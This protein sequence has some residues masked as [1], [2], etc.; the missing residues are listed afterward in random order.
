M[1]GR[2]AIVGAGMAGLA[3]AGRL[4]SAGIVATVFDKG[5]R[6]SGR[7]AARVVE[8]GG[9]RFDFDY[10]AQYMTARDCGFIA[11]IDQWAAQG[12]V[13]RWPVAGD[14]AWVGV[15]SMDAPLAAMERAHPVEWSS[16]VKAVQRR[17]DRW[18]LDIDG[19]D[20]GAFDELIL[21]LPAEQ[22]GT[23]ASAAAPELAVLAS[24]YPSA[25]CWT[26]MLGFDRPIDAPPLIEGDGIIDRACRM[27]AKPG[28]G[29]GEGWIVHA[30]ADWSAAHLEFERA[31]V[32]RLLTAALVDRI[33]GL[34]TPI[35]AAAHRWRFARS[36]PAGIGCYRD[37][38]IGIAACGDW[39][40]APRVESAWLSGVAA[41]EALLADVGR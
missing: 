33:E 9:H 13:A 21:A 34:P 18:H 6:P 8:A 20:R 29:P 38:A 36:S 37:A 26:L 24:K 32:S 40:T 3:C 30:R 31:E 19:I 28:R 25:P 39:L 1:T 35:Y 2:I 14:D 4:A 27:S 11:Q 22:T 12:L 41:A 7:L 15:P 16:H 23:I 17:S 5:R 10:G